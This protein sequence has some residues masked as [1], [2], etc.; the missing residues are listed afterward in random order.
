DSVALLAAAENVPGARTILGTALPA[1]GPVRYD[2]ILSNP[3]LHSG[4]A[5]D[6]RAL[7]RL[8]A[9]APKF[10]KAGGLLQMVVQRR[11]PLDARLKERLADPAVVAETGSFRVWRARAK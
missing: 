5:E 11:V 9:E 3:P 6:H 10:L 8:I 7:E 2:A 4:L 1:A